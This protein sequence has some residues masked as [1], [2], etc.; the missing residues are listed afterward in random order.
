MTLEVKTLCYLW[1]SLV[2][3]QKLQTASM[4]IPGELTPKQSLSLLPD[5]L[6]QNLQFSKIS[7]NSYVY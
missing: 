2:V 5:L 4:G 1:F 3:T 6:N 7:Y